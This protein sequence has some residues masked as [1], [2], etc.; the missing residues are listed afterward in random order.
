MHYMLQADSDRGALARPPQ[1]QDSADTIG[2]LPPRPPRPTH[3]SPI[4]HL[5]TSTNNRPFPKIHIYLKDLSICLLEIVICTS[6]DG[7]S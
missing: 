6:H 2:E 5:Q 4:A 3:P 1:T 7:Q